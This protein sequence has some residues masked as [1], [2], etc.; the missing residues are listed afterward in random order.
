L[1]KFE[2]TVYISAAYVAAGISAACQCPQFLKEKFKPPFRVK[3]D[4]Y[5]P[6]VRFDFEQGTNAEIAKGTIIIYHAGGRR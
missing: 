6:G 3:I 1:S 4:E 2:V 5:H